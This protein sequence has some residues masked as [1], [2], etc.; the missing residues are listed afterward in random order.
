M[1]ILMVVDDDTNQ[2]KLLHRVFSSLADYHVYIFDCA[3]EALKSAEKR[4]YDVVISDLRMPQTDGVTFLSKMKRLQPRASRIMMSA[5]CDRQAL[6]GAINV[7]NAD[8][9]LEKPCSFHAVIQ[10]VEE[11]LRDKQ[12]QVELI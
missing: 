3:E 9:F 7:A 12:L 5:H 1:P 2:L 10:V 8:R 11:V 4:E 6:Y